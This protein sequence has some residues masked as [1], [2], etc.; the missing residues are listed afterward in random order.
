MTSTR[1]LVSELGKSLNVYFGWNKA[2]MTCFTKMLVSL[3][4][5]RTVNLN[6]IAC[7]M[8]GEVER[9]RFNNTLPAWCLGN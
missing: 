5:T 4:V 8:L 7:S 6:K 2:R 1:H 9:K 3:L